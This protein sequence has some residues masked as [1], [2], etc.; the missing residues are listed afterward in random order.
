MGST[1]STTAPGHART[2][3]PKQSP[4]SSRGRRRHRSRSR[5]RR[6]QSPLG[7]FIRGRRGSDDESEDDLSVSSA[8]SWE[9]TAPPSPRKPPAPE[10]GTTLLAHRSPEVYVE[11][12]PDLMLY[13][14]GYLDPKARHRAAANPACRQLRDRVTKNREVWAHLCSSTPWRI[15]RSDL[16]HR[17]V[18]ALRRL[19]RSVVEAT[20][21]VDTAPIADIA[22]IMSDHAGGGCPSP[23]L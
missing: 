19:H 6:R 13:V 16:E 4:R 23:M 15:H 17:P 8:M 12:T 7:L 14:L 11:L 18:N 1:M 9:A 20:D 22:R 10:F 21:S 2:A 3:E 5:G